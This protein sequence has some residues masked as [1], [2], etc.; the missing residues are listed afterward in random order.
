MGTFMSRKKM[1]FAVFAGLVLLAVISLQAAD[2]EGCQM[3]HRYR[4]LGILDETDERIK[5]FYVD[6]TYYDRML[7]PHA[8]L[9]CTDCHE[10]TEVAVLPHK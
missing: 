4:G 5:L 7:G 3:C 6:P 1:V 10:R 9:R 8:R 2:P